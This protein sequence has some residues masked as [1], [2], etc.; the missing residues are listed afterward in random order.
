MG[1]NFRKS[2]SILPGVKLNL[3][4]SGI[5]ISAGVKGA[6]IS[7]SAT[8]RKTV[9]GGIPGSGLSYRKS[10]KS[11]GSI[12]SGS[13]EDVEE[14][15]V[16]RLTL[17]ESMRSLRWLFLM[18]VSILVVGSTGSSSSFLSYL[19]SVITIA[20]LILYLRESKRLKRMLEERNETE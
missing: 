15:Q 2:K 18:V 14:I 1:F 20:F 8:G 13:H 4:K 3:S 11:G 17:S 5:G 7:R 9:S 6:R 16:Q 19:F 12:S 10:I